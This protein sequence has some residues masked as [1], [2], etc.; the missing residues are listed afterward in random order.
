MA[1]DTN[2]PTLNLDAASAYTL[3]SDLICGTTMVK[4]SDVP[5]L[6][7][8]PANIVCVEATEFGVSSVRS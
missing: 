6:G 1:E 5:C 2:E 8:S 7:I 3:P 4:N